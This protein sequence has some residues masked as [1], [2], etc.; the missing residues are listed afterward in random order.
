[1]LENQSWFTGTYLLEGEKTTSVLHTSTYR[2]TPNIHLQLWLWGCSLAGNTLVCIIQ[3]ALNLNSALYKPSQEVHTHDHRIWKA[4]V[5][6]L[7]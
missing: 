4:K 2:L 7:L 6:R 1:M 3:E 5:G